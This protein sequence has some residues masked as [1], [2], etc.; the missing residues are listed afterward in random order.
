M[1]KA[2]LVEELVADGARLLHELDRSGFP[3][4]SM[5]WAHL[6]DQGYWRLIIATPVVAEADTRAAYRRLN[7]VLRRTEFAGITLGDI[8]VLDPDSPDF[9]SMLRLASSSSYLAAGPCWARLEDAV[10]YR[11]TEALVRGE[12]SCNATAEDLKRFW[13]AARSGQSR[14]MLLIDMQGRRFTLRLHPQHGS[15]TSIEDVMPQ[16]AA[17]LHRPEARPDCHITWLEQS[18]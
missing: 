10:V 18:A 8:T 1:V 14:P 15:Q 17:A 9:H 13:D 12:L 11:W 16:F 3:V 7:D 2:T 6:P 5:F 4:S